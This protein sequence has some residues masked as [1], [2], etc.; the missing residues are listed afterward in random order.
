MNSS[1]I[2]IILLTGPPFISPEILFGLIPPPRKSS[3]PSAV[4]K[5]SI[6]TSESHLLSRHHHRRM[7]DVE[8]IGRSMHR[9]IQWKARASPRNHRPPSQE[10]GG[11]Q[12]KAERRA[13][14]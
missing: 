1:R 8:A 5:T 9:R 14:E 12:L 13:D 3:G 6:R 11:T 2:Y 4:G 7:R 10:L